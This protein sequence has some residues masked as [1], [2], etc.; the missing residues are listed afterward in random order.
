ML[1]LFDNSALWTH[2]DMTLRAG[3]SGTN[4]ANNGSDVIAMALI[5]LEQSS[6]HQLG[7]ITFL[8]ASQGSVSGGVNNGISLSESSKW[9]VYP[10]VGAGIDLSATNNATNGA[11]ISLSG[12][13]TFKDCRGPSA[14]R[15]YPKPAADASSDGSC[16][17]CAC[18]NLEQQ[19]FPC[20]PLPSPSKPPPHHTPSSSSASRFQAA[21]HKTVMAAVESLLPLLFVV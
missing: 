5:T 11:S 14:V 9:V 21:A 8:G 2:G 17:P 7:L 13:S 12:S 15:T 19:L 6:L 16:A 10:C 20:I 1:R 4:N 3:T 18:A